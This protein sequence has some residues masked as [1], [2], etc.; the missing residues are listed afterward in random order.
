M[1]SLSQTFL[2]RI[3]TL[4]GHSS[5]NNNIPINKYNDI[6]DIINKISDKNANHN[7]IVILAGYAGVFS[8]WSFNKTHISDLY[9]FIISTFLIISVISFIFF[10]LYQMIK[11]SNFS[12]KIDGFFL[13]ASSGDASID[14]IQMAEIMRDYNITQISI[15]KTWK[16]CLYTSVLFAS[17]S[18]SLLLFCFFWQFYTRIFILDS[19]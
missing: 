18:T 12:L 3:G 10:N 9:S 7:N 6:I 4:S 16:W 11:I 5:K 1:A 15:R 8:I 14:E 13:S 19:M 2:M 17:F